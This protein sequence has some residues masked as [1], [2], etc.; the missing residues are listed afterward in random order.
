MPPVYDLDTPDN[1]HAPH[2]FSFDRAGD[3]KQR[4]PS[5][6]RLHSQNNMDLAVRGHPWQAAYMP[7]DQYC[8]PCIKKHGMLIITVR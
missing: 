7:Q 2:P 1:V 6:H 4:C 3:R 8:R 5:C